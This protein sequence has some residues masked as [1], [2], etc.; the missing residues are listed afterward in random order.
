[1]SR[2]PLVYGKDGQPFARGDRV[3]YDTTLGWRFPNPRMAELFPLEG[4]GE[5]GENFAERWGVS[6]ADQDA[7]ALESQRRW[8]AA[9]AAGRFADEL[10]P[11]GELDR[12]EHPRPQS[13]PEALAKL[14]TVFRD[15]GTVTAGNSSGV[16]DGA[17]ALVIASAEAAERLGVQPLLRFVGSAAAGVDPRVLGVGP[18]PAVRKL[19]DRTGIGVAGAA[20]PVGG[21][22]PS[23]SLA[24]IR[25][26][27]WD[28]GASTSTAARS[29]SSPW[30]MSGARLAGQP[31]PRAA[32]SRRHF[33]LASSALASAVA[34]PRWR[35]RPAPPGRHGDVPARLKA[36]GAADDGLVTPHRTPAPRPPR[37][38]LALLLGALLALLLAAAPAGALVVQVETGSGP[39][40]VGLQPTSAAFLD[41]NGTGVKG[42]P[43]AANFNNPGGNP[44]LHSVNAYVVYW[45][46]M[47]LYSGEEQGL[48][49]RYMS[50]LSDASDHGAN[51]VFAVDAQY[52]DLSG[53]A[54]AKP[55]F[56]GAYTD[57]N[58]YPKASG[59]TD[60]FLPELP[61]NVACV[62]DAQ[63]REQLH[64]FIAQHSLP[65][66]MGTIFFLLTPPGVGVCIDEGLNCSQDNGTLAAG[67]FCSDHSYYADPSSGPCCMRRSLERR[68]HRQDVRRHSR[69]RVPGR[70]LEPKCRKGGPIRKKKAPQERPNQLPSA[71]QRPLRRGSRRP[72]GRSDRVRAA[73]HDHRPPA[74]RL[75]GQRDAGR[76]KSRLRGHRRVPRLL[77]THLWWQRIQERTHRSGRPLQP[78]LE[79]RPL[80]PERCFQPGRARASLS[81]C[82]VPDRDQPP[83]LLHRA[84]GGQ[85]RAKSSAS[86]A[87][88][89]TSP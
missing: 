40:T 18:V 58:A 88:S 17:A 5:T 74:Q 86:T 63:I 4:M 46:P 2:A 29:R 39:H 14:R 38:A 10:I 30:G 76:R 82:A 78:D 21:R 13:N 89:R 51:D 70:G 7:F 37:R 68:R 49:D 81:G 1:M 84:P 43:D 27:D 80:L 19:L 16:N 45:D 11:I 22:S 62:N 26:R 20:D 83:A 71:A 35:A 53:N 77:P 87:W 64:T 69:P 31:R 54:T 42:A 48:I 8:A 12:D 34:R 44:V 56:L 24:V 75:A 79:R 73:E 32:P 85:L 60:E 33:G 59:C 28:P 66:G 72:D 3:V 57:T 61:A 23:Q 9:D 50:E 6:R 25:G 67:S 47:D 41:G 36:D 65:A 52:T 55:K 15:G